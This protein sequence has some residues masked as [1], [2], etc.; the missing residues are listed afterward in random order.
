MVCK[1]K[2]SFILKEKEQ[3]SLKE[4]RTKEENHKNPDLNCFFFFFWVVV[5]NENLLNLS[6]FVNKIF[7]GKF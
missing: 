3:D 6:V 2:I 5:E 4:K 7:I 1:A